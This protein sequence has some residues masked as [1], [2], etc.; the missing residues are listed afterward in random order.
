MKETSY[1]V[2]LI[3]IKDIRI[4]N[5]RARNKKSLKDIENNISQVG[6]KKPVTVR[7]ANDSTNQKYD[8]ICGQGR[9]QC[10][11]A[12]G[13]TEVPAIVRPDITKE[14]AFV[15][16]LVENIARRQ[17]SP[18]DLLSGIGLLKE[19]GYSIREIEQKTGLKKTYISG[20]LSLAEK[21]EERL[22]SAVEKGQIPISIAIKIANSSAEEQDILQDVYETGGIKGKKFVIAQRVLK[23]RRAQGKTTSKNP[24]ERKGEISKTQ[25]VEKV[26]AEADRMKSVVEKAEWT[27]NMLSVVT[28]SFAQLFQ[29]EN[30]KTLLQTEG[31]QDFPRVLETMI[32]EGDHMNV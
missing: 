2:Q 10:F 32:K 15:M 13:E 16:S 8:L 6:L 11:S 29:D 9:L 26:K 24:L 12:L 27:D 1:K 17:H 18:I 14:E 4:V 25:V 31:L 5:D 28:E 23:E 7:P 30:F 22:L 19:Q 21:G 20:I 3:P